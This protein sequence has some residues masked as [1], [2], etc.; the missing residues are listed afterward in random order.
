MKKLLI[1]R[2]THL[3]FLSMMLIIIMLSSCNN[4]DELNGIPVITAVRNYAPAPNDTLVTSIVPGQWIVIHGSNLKEATQISF[5]GSPAVFDAALF[6]DQTAVLQIPSSLPFNN[7]APD[8]VNTIQYVTKGGTTTFR[9]NVKAP[10]ATIT[11]NSMSAGT[12]VG[13]SV[14]VY[15]TN[16][17]LIE[18]LTIAG[19]D[20]SPLAKADDGSSVGFVLPKIDAPMPWAGEI[21][22]ASGTYKFN[23]LIVPE[24]FAIS[25]ANPSQ[26]DSIRVYGKN[27]NGITNFKFGGAVI[28][29]FKEAVDGTSVKFLAPDMNFASGPVSIINSYGTVTTAYSINTK[30]ELWLGLLANFEWGDYFGYDWSGD[31]TL[32]QNVADFNGSMG[33]NRSQYVYFD[34]PALDAGASKYAPLGNSNTG[35]KWI[36]VSN[37]S[38]PV[39]NWAIQFEISV[40]RPWNGGTL[41]FKTEFADESFVA[42]YE[43][44]KIP[45]SNKTLAVKTEG[46][47]TVTIP[48]SE[49]RSK[50]VA[51]GD[52]DPVPSLIK[53]LGPTGAGKYNITLKNFTS[54]RT[55]TGFYG[56]IDN[57]RVVKIKIK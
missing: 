35:N 27:L 32:A 57:I 52:G 18:K 40:A 23:V 14:Y 34:S 49:F 16:L 50:K 10:P 26:G 37:L 44:W 3:L 42:R 31:I 6:S 54:S 21:V 48:L 1:N 55:A 25:N 45:G 15:G 7:L 43:P 4:D 36:P 17:Y 8:V 13:D 24:I 19:T 29:D 33:T 5:N 20:I 53:L 41:Y 30:N 2:V 22:A 12:M 9:F 56:A 47:Q 11:G 39:E 28:T 51:L 38:D 46:W